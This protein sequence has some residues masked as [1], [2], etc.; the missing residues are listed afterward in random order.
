MATALVIIDVQ[1]A[2]LR[3]LGTASRQPII[4]AALDQTIARLEVV[5]RSARNAGAPVV[6]VQHAT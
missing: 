1:N 2:I 5:Q 4:D 3:G 6:V